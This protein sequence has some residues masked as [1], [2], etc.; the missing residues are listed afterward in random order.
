M[1]IA[2]VGT[3]SAGCT[4]TYTLRKNGSKVH[5]SKFMTKWVDEPVK[6]SVRDSTQGRGVF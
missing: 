3:G 2:V 5:L 6:C 4:A 1:E